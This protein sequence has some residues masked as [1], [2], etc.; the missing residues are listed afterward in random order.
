MDDVLIEF[1]FKNNIYTT[2]IEQCSPIS[3]LD[4]RGPDFV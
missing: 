4:G 1:K 2:D 3:E